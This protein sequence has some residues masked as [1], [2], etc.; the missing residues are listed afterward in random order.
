M[1]MVKYIARLHIYASVASGNFFE[2]MTCKYML[3]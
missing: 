2:K 1:G 3:K